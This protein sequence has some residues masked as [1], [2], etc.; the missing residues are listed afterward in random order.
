MALCSRCTY[1]RLSPSEHSLFRLKITVGCLTSTYPS[2]HFFVTRSRSVACGAHIRAF[3]FL[4]TKTL[5]RSRSVVWC[6]HVVLCV[7]LVVCVLLC[8]V[9]CVCCCVVCAVC[10]VC[11]VCSVCCMC[12]VCR[13]FPFAFPF[14]F[15]LFFLF[16]FLL[17][18]IL[19]L[20]LLLFFLFFFSILFSPTKHYGKNRSTNTAANIEA[21]ECDLAQGKCTAVGSLPPP[22][23]ASVLPH[24]HTQ[25]KKRELF[26]YRNIS[27][28]GFIFIT[29]LD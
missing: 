13:S 22:P 9:C 24:S 28:E 6:V 21:F 27:G 4:L 14:F 10:V 11:G 19:L 16:L 3:T 25:K 18:L 26:Y 23:L 5:S 29:V 1:G 2:I 12:C 7:V 15:S 17:L 20:L 8:C